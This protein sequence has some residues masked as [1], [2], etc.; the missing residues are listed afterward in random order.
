MK[1]YLGTHEPNWLVRSTQPLFI[2]AVRLRRQRS[3]RP[4]LV[5]W[6]LDS[7]GFSELSMHGKWTVS[8]EQYAA[9]VQRWSAQIGRLDWA[10]IQ[11]WMCEPFIIAKTG[12]SI[13][14]HQER[15]IASLLRLRELAPAAP[16]T[17]VI[18]GWKVGDYVRHVEAYAD[19]GVDLRSAPIVGVGSVCRRQGTQ[20]GAE[21]MRTLSRAGIAVHAF[22]IKSG[23]LE[24]FGDDIASA[25]SM[26]WSFGARKRQVR[27]P[28]CSHKTCGNC[29]RYAMLW[30]ADVASRRPQQV[31]WNW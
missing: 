15:T 13:A 12:K 17:P 14:E 16:W 24:L 31:A 28:G 8:P 7:G 19:A 30:G 21:I 3:W 18:Q 2:S 29:F 9:E 6:A 23:G 5:D 11:D 26:A 20:E 4:S 10:A 25:D 1:F 27:L 22:G